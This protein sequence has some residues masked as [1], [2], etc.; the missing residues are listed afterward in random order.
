[1]SL[2]D[3]VA[4]L[5]GAKTEEP[6]APKK[7]WDA[8]LIP[9]FPESP[10]SEE[11]NEIDAIL[12]DVSIL[13]AYARWCG[14]MQPQVGKRSE[15]IM[16]SC[17][18]VAHPDKH[19]SAW[20]NSAKGVGNCAVCGGFD[21]YDIAA[22]HFGFDV[23]GY[24]GSDFPALRRAMVED[25]GYAVRRTKSGEQYIE[26]LADENAEAEPGQEPRAPSSESVEESP[27]SSAQPTPASADREATVRTLHAVPE[28]EDS[29]LVAPSIDW[30][31]LL[32][33]DTFLREY[34]ETLSTD[35]SPEEYHFWNGMTCVALAA[36]HDAIL[37]DK[38]PV[39][40]NLFVCL[41]GSSGSGKSRSTSPM[42]NLLRKALVYDHRDM[43][44]TGTYITPVPGSA[45][46]LID[47]FS[48]PITGEDSK[49]IIG[50]AGVRGLVRFDELASL[51]G[52]AARNGS[53][54][55]STLQEFYD[56]YGPVEIKS[57]TAG[58][59]RAEKH[60]CCVLTTTQPGAVRDLLVQADADSGF[61]NRIIFAAGPHKPRVAYGG[62]QIN[63]SDLVIPLNQLR[64]W[65][66][67]QRPKLTLEGDALDLWSSFF[68]ER[69]EPYQE[70]HE[71]SL[72]TRSDLTLKK[73][74]L[75]FCVNEKSEPTR[76]MLERVLP[77][78]DYLETTYGMLTEE[79]GIGQFEDC[80]LQ[81]GKVIRQLQR[82]FGRD[83]ATR[84]INR[85]M[86]R[87][88]QRDLMLRVLENMSE[89][90]EIKKTEFKGKRGTASAV[91]EYTA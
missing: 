18:N 13:D 5:T 59:A 75:L 85:A 91:W 6:R 37:L 2:A 81:L 16:V 58:I 28:I 64:Q 56:S 89:L 84:E 52:R 15:S 77:L 86:P 53:V 49:D 38:T 54:L 7:Q 41:Y 14:K 57:R 67:R 36:G 40:A 47:S 45:E 74:M 33:R 26:E 65:T 20:I 32:P 63:V 30:E 55:K 1:M 34:M 44:S 72:M 83:P 66:T 35:D 78:F 76:E 24:K 62:D 43:D 11:Q 90:G 39:R 87:R 82:D 22:W 71:R 29:A 61:I 3:K 68:H 12:D 73:L 79:I 50:Y 88:Y 25:L 8:D 19:P 9:D 27:A 10:R 21:Q 31:D 23:P 4:A 17:P 80:R 69:I 46:S 70:S 48:K 51:I 60:F 42:L